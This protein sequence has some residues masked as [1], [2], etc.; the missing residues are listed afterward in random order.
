MSDTLGPSAQWLFDKAVRAFPD[1]TRDE[2][3]EARA[4]AAWLGD[5]LNAHRKQQQA[6]SADLLAVFDEVRGIGPLN[7]A[8]SREPF[9]VGVDTA[10]WP[11]GGHV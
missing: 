10:S 11:R 1:A 5:R 9:V 6:A 7:P 3:E 2:L 4:Y 8:V